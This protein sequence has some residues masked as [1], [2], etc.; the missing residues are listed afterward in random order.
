MKATTYIFV[1]G[2]I[3]VVLVMS[4]LVVRMAP[5]FSTVPIVTM[6][7][8]VSMVLRPTCSQMKMAN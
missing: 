1:C 6:V 2:P 5:T 4:V 8:T 3:N 7:V